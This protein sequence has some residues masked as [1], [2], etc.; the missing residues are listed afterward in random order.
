M[1]TEVGADE[2]VCMLVLDGSPLAGP[3]EEGTTALI[4]T[5]VLRGDRL[6]VCVTTA[7]LALGWVLC[8]QVTW[9]ERTEATTSGHS[10][11]EWLTREGERITFERHQ[12]SRSD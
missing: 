6:G 3:E 1:H 7:W 2:L 11:Q 8:C 10:S 5:P 12:P 9:E 4:L